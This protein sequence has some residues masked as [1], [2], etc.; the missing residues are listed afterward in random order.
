MSSFSVFIPR[1]FANIGEKRIANVFYQNDIGE[2]SKVDLVRRNN[3]KGESFN[4]AFVHFEYL[5]ETTSAKQFKEDVEN[6]EVKAKLV[7]EDPWF[8]L[9]LPFEEKEKP[10][11][12]QQQFY[13]QDQQ[14]YFM[15]YGT[16]MMTP[17]GPM[18]Y[19][20]QA[21]MQAPMQSPM[22][23]PQV[24]YG[25]RPSRQRPHPKKRINVPKKEEVLAAQKQEEEVVNYGKIQVPKKRNRTVQ[26]RPSTPEMP[27][28]AKEDGEED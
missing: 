15:G 3:D 2:V 18:W 12:Q 20:M 13:P 17:Q 8:W 16:M 23:P 5:F 6:P 25:N 14:N 4:M 24:A 7:Y 9:V 28:P 11:Q 21:P 1:V 19:P 22:V 27:P 26:K 10:V